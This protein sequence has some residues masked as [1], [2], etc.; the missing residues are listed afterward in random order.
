MGG[1]EEGGEAGEEEGKGFED[2]GAEEG[3]EEVDVVEGR[4]EF[5]VINE[6]AKGRRRGEQTKT[7]WTTNS[8]TS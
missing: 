4:V 5:P 8:P 6:S 2:G 3:S 7:H 1:N